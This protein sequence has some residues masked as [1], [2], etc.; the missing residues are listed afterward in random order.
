MRTLSS[1]RYVFDF[2]NFWQKK[3]FEFYE[4]LSTPA[5]E[6]YSQKIQVKI[7]FLP[8]L[9]KMLAELPEASILKQNVCIVQN[10]LPLNYNLQA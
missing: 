8:E 1:R 5:E 4:S 9:S 6:N 7:L 2:G 3:D 10:L